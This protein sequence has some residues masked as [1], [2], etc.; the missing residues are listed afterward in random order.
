MPTKSVAV[1]IEE[2]QTLERILEESRQKNAVDFWPDREEQIELL[3]S[4]S[5][6]LRTELL[7]MSSSCPRG[8]SE[9]VHMAVCH[10]PVANAHNFDYLREIA[11]RL[12]AGKRDHA[13]LIWL[14]MILEVPTDRLDGDC[15]MSIFLLQLVLKGIATRG[16]LGSL[17]I[18]DDLK[19][20]KLFPEVDDLADPLGEPPSE[21]RYW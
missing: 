13:D 18:D 21:P 4:Q 6:S 10:L 3:S 15:A 11:D 1:L 7:L 9:F 20:K 16:Y 5:V 2:L 14:R 19:A 12:A 17:H 8:A